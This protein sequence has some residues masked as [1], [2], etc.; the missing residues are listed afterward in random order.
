MRQSRHEQAIRA[1]IERIDGQIEVAEVNAQGIAQDLDALRGQR[2]ML[3]KI[4]EDATQHPGQDA[5]DGDA[6]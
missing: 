3:E 2:A 5:G 4:L 6:A 1:E